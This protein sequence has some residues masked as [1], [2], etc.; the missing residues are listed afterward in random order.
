MAL[1]F[2]GR[3]HA[4]RGCGA[5]WTRFPCSGC[6]PRWPCWGVPSPPTSPRTRSAPQRSCRRAPW[7]APAARELPLLERLATPVQNMQDGTFMGRCS[8]AMHCPQACATHKKHTQLL[9]GQ[10]QNQRK[11]ACGCLF[12]PKMSD[13][14]ML[15]G[16]HAI[17]YHAL[18]NRD[19]GAQHVSLLLA[20]W[21]TGAAPPAAP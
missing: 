14:S 19:G 2:S 3:R 17:P 18:Y 13:G 10:S 6:P 9:C 12:G 8:S 21:A 11:K 4:C 20:G 1:G 15:R 16:M 5:G 7:R